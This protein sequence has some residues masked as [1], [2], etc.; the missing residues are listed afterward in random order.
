MSSPTT[1]KFVDQNK[2]WGFPNHDGTTCWLNSILQTICKSDSFV[3]CIRTYAKTGVGRL[4]RL[5][6]D[7][8]DAKEEE[9]FHVCYQQ[10]L[11]YIITL[12]KDFATSRFNDSHEVLTYIINHLHE[13][14][15][16]EIPELIVKQLKDVASI[17]IMRD[18]ERKISIML[19][20]VVSCVVRTISD[21][22]EVC[23]TFN[24]LFIEP[25]LLQ[26][27]TYSVQA[28]ISDI[29]FASIPKCL[30]VKLLIS[31]ECRCRIPNGVQIGDRKYNIASIVFYTRM[32]AATAG[33]Y[34]TAVRGSQIVQEI[35]MTTGEIK[36][37]VEQIGWYI[38]NDS[39][40]TFV[41]ESNFYKSVQ[42]SY[43][44]LISYEQIIE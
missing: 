21:G 8:F 23:E 34:F 13:E 36:A 5:L 28:S 29:Q 18:F 42:A 43:P 33:H 35:V 10:L 22:S 27:G 4:H 38:C 31:K 32:N 30:F 26:D 7:L 2:P 40:V 1:I 41:P 17:A 19:E 24:T 14:S 20:T 3:A 15:G 11:E 6:V 44:T 9:H 37:S 16:K 12:N 39:M 25:K